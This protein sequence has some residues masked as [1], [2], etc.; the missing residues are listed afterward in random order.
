MRN[1]FANLSYKFARFMYG[2]NGLDSLNFFL[3]II[4]MCISLAA[5]F[6]PL[7]LMQPIS[8]AILV[9]VIYRFFS[10][11]LQKRYKENMKFCSIKSSFFGKF[12]LLKNKFRDRKTHRYYSCPLCKTTLRVPKGRGKISIK[13]PKC[14]C[15]IIKKT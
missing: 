7:Y 8:S 3:I 6:K 2:R 5:S 11:N 4:S 1:F 12:K 10:K 14:E 9:W 15:K 13:C